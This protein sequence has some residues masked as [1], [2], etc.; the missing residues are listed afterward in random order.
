MRSR[1]TVGT[2]P[3]RFLIGDR[4]DLGPGWTSIELQP[5]YRG[6]YCPRAVRN[7][8]Q[9][10]ALNPPRGWMN[11]VDE[12]LVHHGATDRHGSH[13]GEALAN[14]IRSWWGE[15]GDVENR[16]GYRPEHWGPRAG[17]RAEAAR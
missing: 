12:L 3:R 14:L 6:G 16:D 2:S 1:A 10:F 13:L 11:R 4:I 5:W 17:E 7:H 9:P 15:P 8:D